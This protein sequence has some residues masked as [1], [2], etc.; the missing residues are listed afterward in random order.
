MEGSS[1]RSRR[2]PLGV[3]VVTVTF[4]FAGLVPLA[5]G[6][7]SFE[8]GDGG[9]IDG[10]GALGDAPIAIDGATS[11]DGAL[12]P[13]DASVDRAPSS[14]GA[15]AEGATDGGIVA[16]AVTP[17]FSCAS[18]PL[19]TVFCQDFDSV[20]SPSDNWSNEVHYGGATGAFDKID[21]VSAPN[22]YVV[23]NP[24]VTSA[25]G[26]SV[27]YSFTA[28]AAKIEYSFSAFVK[29]IDTT[30]DATIIAA[31]LA[32]GV[33]VAH[34][35]LLDLQIDRN[36]VRLHQIMPQA[37]GSSIEE[38]DDVSS[39]VAMNKWMR[40]RIELDRGIAPAVR[41]FI[42]DVKRVEKAPLTP[43][44]HSTKCEV[45]LGMIFVQPPSGPSSLTYDNVLVRAL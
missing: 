27:Q 35:L 37:D 13:H 8:A 6:G 11:Q 42:D 40:V 24:A 19:G 22:G 45:D 20:S 15:A 17:P 21:F 4:T 3:G 18:P 41:V 23:R 9:A 28:A 29:Q 16:D 33:T 1:L 5:C 44:V 36:G 34:D 7:E 12:P 10:D 25:A 26:A 2:S 14:D 32:V 39:A 31:R 30:Q 43:S 38:T